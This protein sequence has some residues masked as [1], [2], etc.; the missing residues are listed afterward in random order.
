VKTSARSLPVDLE[1]LSIA[2]EAETADLRWYLDV[3][4]GDV[5]LVTPEFEPAEHDGLTVTEIENEPERFVRVPPC[6]PQQVVDDMKAFVTS[7]GDATLQESLELALSASRPEK[8]FKTALSWLPERQQQWHAWHREHSQRRALSW[9][10][11][12][13]IVPTARAA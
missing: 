12:Q 4:T 2:L 6:N 5:L 10:E 1:E 9:L 3:D 11:E 7:L 13:G 8:R